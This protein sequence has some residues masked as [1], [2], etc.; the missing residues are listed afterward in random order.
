MGAPGFPFEILEPFDLEGTEL[1]NSLT[2][3]GIDD[4]IGSAGGGLQNLANAALHTAG[5]FLLPQPLWAA[6]LGTLPPPPPR[7]GKAGSLSPFKPV[8]VQSNTIINFDTGPDNETPVA[9]GTV[10]NTLYSSLGVTFQHA[11]TG[12]SCEQHERLR[13]LRPARRVWIVTEQRVAVR[14]KY[15]IGHQREHVWPDPGRSSYCC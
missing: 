7:S 5:R 9:D 8:E 4:V 14:A 6:T 2:C 13:E 10:V 3:P 12:G 11:G 15:R 1:R